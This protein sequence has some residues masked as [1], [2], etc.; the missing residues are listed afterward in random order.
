MF[1]FRK[2]DRL[3]RE[4][5]NE[6]LETPKPNQ[7]TVGTRSRRSFDPKKAF[8]LSN[9]NFRKFKYRFKPITQCWVVFIVLAESVNI[10][11]QNKRLSQK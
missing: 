6:N 7:V 9:K 1:D 3:S 4:K 10:R 5:Y 11:L 8:T 2:T